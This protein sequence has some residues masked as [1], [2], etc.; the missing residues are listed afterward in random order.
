MSCRSTK[1]TQ[2]M[3]LNPNKKYLTQQLTSAPLKWCCFLLILSRA[4]NAVV[5]IQRSANV[6]YKRNGKNSIRKRF[7]HMQPSTFPPKLRTSNTS[8]TTTLHHQQTLFPQSWILPFLTYI[9]GANGVNGWG[10]QCSRSPLINPARF[11][12]VSWDVFDILT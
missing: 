2:N 7:M 11:G 12:L 4:A 9:K 6:K 3:M 5:L 1:L 8:Q 10:N